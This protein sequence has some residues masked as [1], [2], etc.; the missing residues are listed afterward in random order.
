VTFV[1]GTDEVEVALVEQA[2]LLTRVGERQAAISGALEDYAAN[3]GVDF[4]AVAHVI[5]SY[6]RADESLGYTDQDGDRE[7]LAL[8]TGIGAKFFLLGVVLGRDHRP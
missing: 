3:M 1:I 5:W 4:R 7:A 2:E 8:L 6:L